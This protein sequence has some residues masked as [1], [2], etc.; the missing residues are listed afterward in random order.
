M[1]VQPG[2]AGAG[3]CK[4]PIVLIQVS[5]QHH[6]NGYLDSVAFSVRSWEDRTGVTREIADVDVACI[7]QDIDVFQT[8][9][10]P[11]HDFRSNPLIPQIVNTRYILSGSKDVRPCVPAVGM[12]LPQKFVEHGGAFDIDDI[13]QCLDLEFVFQVDF[14]QLTTKLTKQIQIFA[15]FN[16]TAASRITHAKIRKIL[17]LRPAERMVGDGQI[18][19]IGPVDLPKYQGTV[20]HAATNGPDFVH[21]PT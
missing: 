11:F 18:F 4:K 8:G 3:Q 21:R 7:A 13:G 14:N 16:R 9:L 17:S 5:G 1:S 12:S 20:F 6:G 2:L 15:F 10:K 19:S